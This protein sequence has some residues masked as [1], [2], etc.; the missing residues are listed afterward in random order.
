MDLEEGHVDPLAFEVDAQALPAG[1]EGVGL[2]GAGLA[3]ANEGGRLQ[4]RLEDQQEH[5]A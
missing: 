5:M 4:L 2:A 1:V 3:I